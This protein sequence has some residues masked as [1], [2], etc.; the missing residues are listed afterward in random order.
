MNPLTLYAEFHIDLNYVQ[1][2]RN[3]WPP[4]GL[5]LL[6]QLFHPSL[7]CPDSLELAHGFLPWPVFLAS[8]DSVS[9]LELHIQL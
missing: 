5:E 2:Q 8:V 1:S 7:F 6:L 3:L 9:I 4:K